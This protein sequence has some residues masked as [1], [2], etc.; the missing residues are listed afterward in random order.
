[1]KNLIIDKP[2]ALKTHHK[3]TYLSVT[4]IFWA[5]TFYLWQPLI[6]LIAWY[7]GFELFYNHMI[8]LGGYKE[9]ADILL[10]YLQVIVLLGAIFLAWAKI[11]ERRFRGKNRRKLVSVATDSDVASYFK[12]EGKLL[13]E[14]MEKKV[15]S[16]DISDDRVIKFEPEAKTKVA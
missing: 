1:M 4:F 10:I 12:V 5:I 16:L 11:N 8:E 13:K 3:I 6:S 14:M 15:L 9:F 7:F 2:E